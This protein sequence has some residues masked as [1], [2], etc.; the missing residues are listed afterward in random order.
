V[1]L[2]SGDTLF[3]SNDTYT[4][5][6][7][8]AKGGTSL[9]Y[10][11]ERLYCDQADSP[12]RC[13]NK[14]VLLKE[15][16][17]LSAEFTRSGSG[18]L[19]F[20]D[21]DVS[22]LKLLFENEIESLAIVQAKNTE[23]NRIPD[24]DSFGDYNNTVYIAMNHIKGE[25]LG[26]YIRKKRM[27]DQEIKDIFTQIVRVVGFLH[28]IDR[29]YCHLDLKPHNFIVDA[30]NS[31]YLFDFGSSIIE[32]ETW[33]N[34][35]TE[36]YSAPEVVYNMLEMVGQR[37]DIYSLGAILFEMVTGE[38]A[39]MDRFLLCGNRYCDE[40]FCARYDYNSI[41]SRMLTEDISQR[42]QSVEEV[43]TAIHRLF[44]GLQ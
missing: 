33:I 23:S 39:S 28:S 44:K 20:K 11:A 38:Y 41:L 29:D 25:L 9:I 42:F 15:L 17:P 2:K 8:L 31:V 43:I 6:R 24:M 35:C 40:S 19:V 3:L 14:K 10:E 1:P 22:A 7:L 30:L 12:K 16:A 13:F 18:E 5:N 37:S 36:D 27:T 21:A 4:I 26:E 32:D 34:N